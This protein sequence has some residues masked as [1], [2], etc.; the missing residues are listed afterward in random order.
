MTKSTVEFG[1]DDLSELWRTR[2][3]LL[4]EIQEREAAVRQIDDVLKDRLP[5]EDHV[6]ATINGRPVFTYAVTDRFKVAG[7]RED[8][9][10][11]YKEYIKPVLKDELNWRKFVEDHPIIAKQYLVRTLMPARPKRRN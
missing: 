3:K 1:I 2:L 7:F 9:P 11:F 8:Y 10:N 5:D 6:T 4:E